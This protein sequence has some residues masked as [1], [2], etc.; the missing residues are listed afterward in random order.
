MKKHHFHHD[1]DFFVFLGNVKEKSILTHIH[2]K[3]LI[4]KFDN[5]NITKS[6]DFNT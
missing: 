1:D 5:R 4:E 3:T 2:T 6:S